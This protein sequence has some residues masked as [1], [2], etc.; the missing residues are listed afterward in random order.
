LGVTQMLKLSLIGAIL[1]SSAFCAAADSN[2]TKIASTETKLE[3]EVIVHKHSLAAHL[4]L[5]K[6]EA[7]FGTER[8][9]RGSKYLEDQRLDEPQEALGIKPKETPH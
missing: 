7:Y 2:E 9:G 8:E 1:C 6:D 4:G 3:T 5:T